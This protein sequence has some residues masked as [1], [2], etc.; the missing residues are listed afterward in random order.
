MSLV[1]DAH[2]HFMDPARIHYH[3][4]EFLPTLNRFVG[5]ETLTPLLDEAGVACTVCVQ[6]ADNEDETAFMLE[7]AARTDRVAG[8]VGWVPLADPEATGKAIAR[9]REAG[10]LL[11]GIRHLLQDE[12]DDWVVQPTVLESLGLLAEAG[13][14]FDVSAFN[15]RHLEHLPHIAERHPELSLVI[16]H[17]GMPKLHEG[18]WEPWASVFARAGEIPR[19][20][21]KISGLDMY[22]GGPS[23]PQTQ[24]YIDHALLHFGAERMLWASNWPV[25]MR[26]EG[27]REL[28]DTAREVLRD[29]SASDR[30][31]IFGGNA[32]RIY[33]LT[34]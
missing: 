10:T 22:L 25:S 6:A 17:M 13:L 30:D 31:A 4:L 28:L 8:V 24:R 9:H 32:S 20:A 21:V 3:F 27:Y 29:C 5:P 14:A 33:G 15:T 16:C 23:A 12:A 34:H 2:H 1:I 19:C 11:R 26:L 18:E 7:Q